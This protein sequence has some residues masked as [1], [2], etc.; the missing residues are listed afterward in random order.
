MRF[1]AKPVFIDAVQWDGTLAGVRAIQALVPTLEI[2]YISS[3][4]PSGTVSEWRISTLAGSKRVCQ[5]GWIIT[6]A[7]GKHYTCD[8]DTFA[9]TYDIA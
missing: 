9:L 6:E 1:V 3:H 8:A 2:V 4:P 7:S 5:G